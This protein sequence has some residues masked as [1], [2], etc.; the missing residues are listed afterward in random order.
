MVDAVNS[1]QKQCYTYDWLNRLTGALALAQARVTADSACLTY[2]TAGTGPYSHSY[3]YNGIGNIVNYSGSPYTYGSS[4]PHAV[5]AAFG[6]MYGYDANGNQTTRTI[7]GVTYDLVFD[8][9]NRIVAVK[10]GTTTIGSFVYDA[11]GN[12]VKGT[13]NG[14][15]TSYVAGLFEWQ[16]GATTKYYDGGA[17]RRTG[18][19]SGNGISYVLSDQL[20][21]STTIVSQAGSALSTNYYFPFGGNRGGSAFSDLTTK[22]FTGQYHEKDL[23]G[24]EGLSYYN[25][26][27]YDAQLGRF[28][29]PD[30][31]IPDATDPQHYNRLAYALNNPVNH[32]DPTGHAVA[33]DD[34]AC[35]SRKEATKSG[36]QWLYKPIKQVNVRR[37]WIGFKS[38]KGARLWGDSDRDTVQS[39][40]R[41]IGNRLS[42]EMNKSNWADYKS[43]MSESYSRLSSEQAYFQVYGRQTFT[44][45]VET[46]EC[47]AESKTN[48][49][50]WIYANAGE[51]DE[52]M[53]VHELGHTFDRRGGS[54]AR[55]DLGTTQ[56]QNPTFPDRTSNNDGSYVGGF[57]GTLY[58][59]QQSP[60][61]TPSEEFADQFIGWTYNQWADSSEGLSRSEWMDRN[62]ALYITLATQY[63][64]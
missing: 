37:Y 62:M 40:V 13:V 11:D 19:G 43:G 42:R 18:Y 4:K 60:S 12:R 22:R 25:A 24:V 41:A 6:N 35:R 17:I 38:Q 21:S 61:G 16:A 8:E 7:G 31:L 2:S 33:C 45:V 53:I 55:Q 27:W 14:V 3:G 54:R 56:R 34:G 39:A 49:E 59:W 10:Q 28:V 47:W 5:T 63:G 9:E 46:C 20:G 32:R 23:P 50:I 64:R 58:G 44:R 48:N 1:N 15:T 52:R 57:A 29:S 30:S 36:I 51:F 26:R